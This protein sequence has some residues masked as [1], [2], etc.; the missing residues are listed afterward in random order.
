M[1]VIRRGRRGRAKEGLKINRA[2]GCE[3][4]KGGRQ[5]GDS[6]VSQSGTEVLVD[7]GFQNRVEVLEFDVANESDYENLVTNERESD[8]RDSSSVLPKLL[9]LVMLSRNK[10]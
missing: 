6:H 5:N 1:P 3:E 7:V 9:P 8:I 2:K 10:T 4:S